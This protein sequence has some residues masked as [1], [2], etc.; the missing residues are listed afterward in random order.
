MDT[1]LSAHPFILLIVE[2]L[3]VVGYNGSGYAKS[4]YD[5]SPYEVRGLSLGYSRQ[6]LSLYPLSKVI[7][8]NDG[9][10]H[11][12]LSRREW[13]NDID[14]PLSERSGAVNRGQAL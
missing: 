3:P 4:A 6:G 8:C 14:S 7:N 12:S 5:R 1:K 2:L 10:P 13:S 11:L 9:V